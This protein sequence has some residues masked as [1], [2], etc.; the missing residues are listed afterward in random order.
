M[1]VYCDRCGTKAIIATSKKIS[2]QVR[3]LYC[4]CT[5]PHC[6]H[7]FVAELTFSH[8]IS[9][10]S[11]DLPQAVQARLEGCGASRGQVQSLLGV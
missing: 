1:R 7:T 2:I 4:S 5:N 10:S 8:T 3:H 6:G 11:L 9:P